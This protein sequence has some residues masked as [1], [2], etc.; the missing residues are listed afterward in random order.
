MT[1]TKN[2]TD[3]TALNL[4]DDF[5]RGKANQF[6]YSLKVNKVLPFKEGDIKGFKKFISEAL[7]SFVELKG[8]LL[9]EKKGNYSP[10]IGQEVSRNYYFCKP[11]NKII[12]QETV[13]YENPPNLEQEVLKDMQDNLRAFSGVHSVSFNGNEFLY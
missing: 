7:K 2:R 12:Y 9:F 11:F 5:N 13:P 4:V 3:Q 6:L 1:E 10:G 8:K